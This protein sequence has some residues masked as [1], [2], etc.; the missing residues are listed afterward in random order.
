M[1]TW[2]HPAQ[3]YSDFASVYWASL[4]DMPMFLWSFKN[5]RQQQ[6]IFQAKRAAV[7]LTQA[8]NPSGNLFL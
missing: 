2:G 4:G 6:R 1:R 3:S 7:A 8:Q 5:H